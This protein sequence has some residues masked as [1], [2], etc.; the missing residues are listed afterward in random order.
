M[1]DAY[2]KRKIEREALSHALNEA[3][4]SVSPQGWYDSLRGTD[5]G[6]YSRTN[7]DVTRPVSKIRE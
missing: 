2:N 3:R 5:D 4:G 7:T 1:G 6:R